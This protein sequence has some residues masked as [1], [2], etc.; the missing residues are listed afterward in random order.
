ML[1]QQVSP[2]SRPPPRLR[3]IKLDLFKAIDPAVLR[4]IDGNRTNR[5][6]MPPQLRE[7]TW[8]VLIMSG[9]PSLDNMTKM[10]AAAAGY[11]RTTTCLFGVEITGNIRARTVCFMG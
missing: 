6:K 4:F 8:R 1:L 7:I 11:M 10:P 2:R 3:S 5:A 9:S